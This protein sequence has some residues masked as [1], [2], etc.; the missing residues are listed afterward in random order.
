MTLE[1]LLEP[2]ATLPAGEARFIR[3]TEVKSLILQSEQEG[4]MRVDIP[5][6]RPALRGRLA[7]LFEE[8]IERSLELRGACSP[9]FGAS[10]NLE[11]C[12]TD[13]LYRA[14]LIGARG[15][16]I[17]LPTLEG[18]TNRMGALDAD[19]S[20]MLRW[21][22][23]SAHQRPI[24]LYLDVAD[25]MLGA[26]LEP[27]T[28][29]HL[30]N[31][32]VAPMMQNASPPVVVEW[33][34]S[35]GTIAENTTDSGAT[36][37]LGSIDASPISDVVAS[38][39]GVELE[40]TVSRFLAEA[41]DELDE[42]LPTETALDPLALEPSIAPPPDSAPIES[43]AIV[44]IGEDTELHADIEAVDP[45]LTP[46][47]APTEDDL[48][49]ASS[50]SHAIPET[51]GPRHEILPIAHPPTIPAPAF[52]TT[53]APLASV[54]ALSFGPL[55]VDANNAWRS[56][57][58]RL[59]AARG[60][61]PLNAIEQLFINAFVPLEDA[62]QRG[63]AGNECRPVLDHWASSFAKSYGEAF[64]AM[65]L[66]GRRP[67]MVLD[68]PEAAQRL[69]RLH[70]ARSVQLVLVDGMRFDLGLRLE[71]QLVERLGQQAILTDRFLLWSALPTTTAQQLEL[72]GRGP[73]GLR[74][75]DIHSETPVPVAR[76]RS[77]STLRRIRTGNRELFKLDLIEARLSEPGG[78]LAERLDNLGQ[79]LG[80]ALAVALG[81]MP[82]RTLVAVFGDHGFC[83]EASDT[84]TTALRQG[85]A[86]PEEVLVPGFAWLVGQTH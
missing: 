51:P 7:W 5:E 71:S 61:K 60:P 44:V 52:G 24:R 62:Y 11:L 17:A 27:V 8:A 10:A 73:D 54:K 26:Y 50:L 64:D 1:A 9:G 84:G 53:E 81:R 3:P 56:W 77:A 79:E 67:M 69:A 41:K 85:G 74:D 2:E 75:G 78:P 18:L 23:Q 55:H 15:F 21:W 68:I 45:S 13:Q 25:C 36:P 12:L 22:L 6:L 80:D 86:S 28:L 43:S 57:M 37:D 40:S 65:R 20:V 82:P 72:I 33:V 83:L 48:A 34:D 14:R 76:G 70:G 31:N 29:A 66:R 30:M 4:Y 58:Q 63:I 42:P 46:I 39:R 38:V 59:D 19:D 16:V 35:A 49:C 32:A 47:A